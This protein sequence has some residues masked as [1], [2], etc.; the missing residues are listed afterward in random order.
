MRA[1]RRPA[2]PKRPD[3]LSHKAAPLPRLSFIH[4]LMPWLEPLTDRQTRKTPLPLCATLLEIPHGPCDEEAPQIKGWVLLRRLS[5]DWLVLEKGVL[6]LVDSD[7]AKGNH[8]LWL[9][10]TGSSA[11]L[12]PL[13]SLRLRHSCAPVRS[14]HVCLCACAPDDY[15][16]PPLPL[17]APNHCQ[18]ISHPPL[19]AAFIYFFFSHE[20][21]CLPLAPRLLRRVLG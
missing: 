3:L 12:C 19:S 14:S 2:S 21:L 13:P 10:R 18:I 20:F 5:W 8:K 15:A 11:Y 9:A 6:V 16:H 1:P 17:F 4:P 7:L